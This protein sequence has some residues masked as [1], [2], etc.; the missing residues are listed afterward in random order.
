MPE[1]EL[2]PL[3]ASDP[4]RVGGFWLDARVAGRES[5]VGFLAHSSTPRAD[6]RSDVIV[7]QLNEGAARDPAARDRFAGMVNALPIDDVVARG[8]EGQDAGRLAK[9]FTDETT[10]TPAGTTPLPPAP[11]VALAADGTGRP[12][13]TADAILRE[14]QLADVAQAG[15]PSGPE[16][17]LPWIDRRGPGVTRIWPLPW[18]GR[19]DRSGW[20]TILVS[21]LLMLLI[22]ALGVLIAILIFRNEPPQSPPPII[23]PS[24]GEG[25]GSQSPPPS[26][27]PSDS[28]SAEPTESA[29]ASESAEPSESSSEEGSA[30][31][32]PTPDSA[33]PSPGTDQSTGPGAPTTR[34]RL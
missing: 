20:V 28:A 12:A 22:A 25:S 9:R 15:E 7:V 16:Y 33:S 27:P 10:D 8:G 26:G 31:S 23:R 34:S 4:P 3:S 19:F 2:Y 29:D 13:A 24:Q 21:W 18:P 5:G 14:V 6:G 11:W 17:Q 32:T 30:S 1:L